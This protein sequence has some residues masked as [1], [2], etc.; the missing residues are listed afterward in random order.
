MRIILGLAAVILSLTTNALAISEVRSI[1]TR[2]G[3]TMDFLYMAPDKKPLHDVMILFAGGNGA[4]PFHVTDKGAAY[5]WNFLVRSVDEFTRLGL[6]VVTVTP[7]SD[8]PTGMSADFRESSEHAE[9]IAKLTTY[10]VSQGFERIFLTGNSRGTLS[11][12]AL[13]SRLKDSHIK[14]IVL[15]STLEYDS[16]MRW[17]PLENVVLPVMMVHHRED[18]CRVCSFGEAKKTQEI[19]QS[20]TIVDFVEVS[21]GAP[22]MTEPCDN[23]SAHEFFGQETKVV[24]AIADWVSGKKIPEKIE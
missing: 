18:A 12:A 23:L 22:P 10:L 9:D 5:G 3:V 19:L 6:A 11:V 8:H 13:A 21:G 20:H 14:G 2:T 24:Q 17:L 16:F 4:F 7:P 1:P 15:T